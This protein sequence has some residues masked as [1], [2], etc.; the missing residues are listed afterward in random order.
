MAMVTGTHLTVITIITSIKNLLISALVTC[1]LDGP[2][3]VLHQILF[4]DTC[5][6]VQ[7]IIWFP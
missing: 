5:H 1:E 3:T 7:I 6:L 2:A 4:V